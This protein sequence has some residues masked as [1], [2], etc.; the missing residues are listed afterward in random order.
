VLDDP[1]ELVARGRAH[2]ARFT[3]RACGDSVVGGYRT[4]LKDLRP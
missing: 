4:V 1:G 3:W 2:A